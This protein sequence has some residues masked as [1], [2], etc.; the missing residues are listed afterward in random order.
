VSTKCLA[1][2]SPLGGS[3]REVAVDVDALDMACWTELMRLVSDPDQIIGSSAEPRAVVRLKMVDRT[4]KH[5]WDTTEKKEKNDADSLADHVRHAAHEASPLTPGPWLQPAA[6]HP[7]PRI[8]PR[9]DAASSPPPL[10]PSR[11]V[12]SPS[13]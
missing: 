3:T 9:S 10:T 13:R 1:A 6:R 7:A 11:C 5:I 8:E 2:F 12:T 4:R